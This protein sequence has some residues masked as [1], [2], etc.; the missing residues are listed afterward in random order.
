M[1]A[2][3]LLQSPIA[4]PT[5]PAPTFTVARAL[6]WLGHD[7]HTHCA[8]GIG[9][10]PVEL[11]FLRRAGILPM[12]PPGALL[13]VGLDDSDEPLTRIRRRIGQVNRC[14]RADAIHLRER[15]GGA[16]GRAL[17]TVMRAAWQERD[18]PFRFSGDPAQLGTERRPVAASR[19][20][21]RS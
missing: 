16:I 1:N 9:G 18:F 14:T 10:L 15:S 17:V 21:E 2:P 3:L 4:Q 20:G 8:A 6:S 19:V 13:L 5:R 12:M 11:W 7:C